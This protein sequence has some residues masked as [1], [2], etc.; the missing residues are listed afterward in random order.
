MAKHLAQSEQRELNTEPRKTE[1]AAKK[2][3][4]VGTS[5]IAARLQNAPWLPAAIALVLLVAVSLLPTEG[6]L[7]ALAYAVPFLL[8]FAPIILC[9]V[10][11]F[12]ERRFL[13]NDVLTLAAGLLLFACGLYTEAVLLAVLFAAGGL[14]ERFLLSDSQ[15]AT[16]AVLSM[17]PDKALVLGED[18]V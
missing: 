11:C 8:A 3:R 12:R 6:W 13:A 15:K 16:D 4:A 9:C 10:Q 1:R 18:G 14:L 7:R 17:L 2:L 5:S